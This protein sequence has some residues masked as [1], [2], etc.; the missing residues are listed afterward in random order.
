MINQQ[1]MQ[2][3]QNNEAA[4]EKNIGLWQKVFKL[5]FLLLNMVDCNKRNKKIM[6]RKIEVLSRL[7]NHEGFSASFIAQ[8]IQYFIIK[9]ID[10]HKEPISIV[11]SDKKEHIFLGDEQN[12]T[13]STVPPK[14]S[15][16]GDDTESDAELNSEQQNSLKQRLEGEKV[17]RM[18]IAEKIRL[19][20]REILREEGVSSGFIS[21]HQQFLAQLTGKAGNSTNI[22]K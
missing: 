21:N 8:C 22:G 9:T 12:S 16:N 3:T 19:D 7:L 10:L 5:E 20:V 13:A 14:I 1:Y 6:K 17:K 15:K 2:N 4:I 11:D 18:K